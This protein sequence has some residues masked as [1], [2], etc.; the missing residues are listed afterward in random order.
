VLAAVAPAALEVSLAAADQAEAERAALDRLWRQRLE[1]AGYAADRA[2]R[3]YQLTE[4]ENRLV[5]RQLERDWEAALAE[6]ERLAADYARFRETQPLTLT[7]AEREAI[8]ALAADLPALWHAATTTD[9]DRKDLLRVLIEKITV[10]V[11]GDSEQVDV[12]ITWAGGH[13]TRGRAIRPVARLDQLSCYRQLLATVTD[14]A[15]AGAN[16]QA[17]AERLNA[18]GL[19]PPK[20]TTR[21]G[22]EQ[23]RSLITRHGLRAAGTRAAPTAVAGLGADRWTV[24]RLATELGMPVATVYNWIYRGWLTAEQVPGHNFW[25]VHADAAELARLRERRARPPGYYTRARWTQPIESASPPE[26][27]PR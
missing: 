9:A 12:T 19:R 2:R 1:R 22:A 20:R 27:S 23:V 26:S 15:T 11:V 8:G 3:Q 21:F 7:A 13:E 18:A 14:L 6:A 4:P 25:I 10:A 16:A 17:I 5:A 24:P